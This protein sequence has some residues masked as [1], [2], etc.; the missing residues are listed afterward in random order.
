MRMIYY[1][2]N[3]N[4]GIVETLMTLVDITIFK[5]QFAIKTDSLQ[6]DDTL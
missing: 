4:R 5:V 3:S 1:N 2:I 6:Y